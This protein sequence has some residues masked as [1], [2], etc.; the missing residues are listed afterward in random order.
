MKSLLDTTSYSGS[1]PQVTG[2]DIGTGSSCI[3]PLIGATHRGWSFYATDIDEKNLKYAARNISNNDLSSIITIL[4]RKL[5]DSLIPELE[6]PIT[7]CMTNPPFYSSQAELEASASAKQD[8]PSSI[9]TGAPVEMV[10][11]GGEV[12]F[13]SRI[14]AES[15]ERKNDVRWYTAML[16]FLSSVTAIIEKIKKNSITNWAVGELTQGT[17]TRRWVVAWSFGAMRPAEDA[18]R[19]ISNKLIPLPPPTEATITSIPE[20]DKVSILANGLRDAISKL[21]LL[22]WAWDSTSL[23]GVGKA[24]G[25]VWNRNWRRKKKAIE[26]TGQEM[27]HPERDTF[28]FKVSIVAKTD[29]VTVHCRWLEGHDFVTFESFQGFLKTTIKGLL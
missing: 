29:D 5:E 21:D 7:F 9:C 3:Y 8:S 13:V 17:K 12:A 24:P 25:N 20:L 1:A 19:Q 11:E 18:C 22:S 6:E 10:T 23:A 27:T 2:L 26:A 15:L 28:G 4:P 16:G 14:L